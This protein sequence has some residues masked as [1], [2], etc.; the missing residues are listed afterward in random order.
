M[1]LYIILACPIKHTR[2]VKSRNC[3]SFTA[4]GNLEC[5]RK[6]DCNNGKICCYDTCY[7]YSI[8]TSPDPQPV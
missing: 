4:E 6:E 1:T 5:K 8:C 3:V 2:S 7:E